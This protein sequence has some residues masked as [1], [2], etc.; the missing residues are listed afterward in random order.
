[1]ERQCELA[2][3]SRTGFYRQL[4]RG[5]PAEEQMQLRDRLQQ[6]AVSGKRRLGYRVLT[7]LLRQE[8]QAVNRKRV[9]RLM[10]ADNLLCLRARQYVFTTDSRHNW[11]IYPNLAP[12]LRLS[13]INQLWVADITFV[14]LRWEF[15]YLA[16]VLDAW[17]RRVI[18]WDL[19][20]SLDA[21]LALNALRMALRE[22]QWRPGE[23]VHHSDRGTQYAAG[24]YVAVL[25]Q[26]EILISMSRKGNPYDNAKA[27]R[28]MRTLKEE[29]LQGPAYGSI[30]QARREIGDFLE[31]TYNRQR[32]HS[33]LGYLT[34]NE[35]ERR[36]TAVETDGR[37]EGQENGHSR[38]PPASTVLGNR[39][40][41]P[42]VPTAQPAGID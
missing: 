26:N 10:R 21:E 4:R 16:V 33:A 31:A 17:S 28:F 41:I 5:A 36:Q 22:R 1:M 38:F 30:A 40:A 9:L 39:D 20:A 42:T 37:L 32:L 2:G 24:D 34:P 18:G 25:E 23:L 11:P 7:F 8:G 29:Q 35:F 14:R 3:V 13:G 19:S 6:L 12:R 27:E 15:V